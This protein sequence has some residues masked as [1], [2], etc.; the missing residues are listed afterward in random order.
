M[1]LWLHLT[2]ILFPKKKKWE[3]ISEPAQGTRDKNSFFFGKVFGKFPDFGKVKISCILLAVDKFFLCH[4]NLFVNESL[5][6]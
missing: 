2:T 6:L 5:L 4:L 1:N 3:K